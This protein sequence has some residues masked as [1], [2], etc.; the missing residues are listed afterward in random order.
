MVPRYLVQLL[1][2]VQ[3]RASL[4]CT[5]AYRHT[6][7]QAL[8]RELSWLPLATRRQQHKLNTFYK[9]HKHI[10]PPYLFKLIPPPNISH[11]NLRRSNERRLPNNRLQS[12]NNSFFPATD[13]VWNTLSPPIKNSPSVIIFK[14]KINTPLHKNPYYTKCSGKHGIWLCRLR[15]G[16]SALNAPHFSY[17]LTDNPAAL[18]VA[19]SMKLQCTFFSNALPTIMPVR[20]CTLL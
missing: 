11:Y 20:N 9:I 16:L 2:R 14:N 13:K 3:R 5:G 7:T 15:L 4:I 12:T 19:Q 1:D 18:I 6:E 17:H 8:L 10:Y